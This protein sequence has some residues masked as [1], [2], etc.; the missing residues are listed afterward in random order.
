MKKTRVSRREFLKA[1]A[2]AAAGMITASLL[3]C[4]GGSG[5]GTGAFETNQSW[6]YLG[7]HGITAVYQP[8]DIALYRQLLPEA[9]QMPDSPLVVVSIVSYDTVTKP[10]VPYREGFVMLSCRHQGQTGMYTLTMPV[11]D[12]TANDAGIYLGF[13]KYVADRIDLAL[14][15]GIWN[16]EVVY[17]GQSVMQLK[18]TPSNDTSTLTR[19][20]PGPSCVNLVPPGVGPDI[21]DVNIIGLQTVKTTKGTA[22]TTVDPGQSWGNLLQGAILVSAQLEQ[23][24][25]DWTLVKG[26]GLNSAVVSIAR[27]KSGRTD[28]AVEEAIALLGGIGAV[29]Q[30]RQKI[31]LKPNLVT[32]NPKS[33]TKPEVVE[34]LA[35]LML[36]AGKEVSIGE[37]SAACKNF[38]ILNGV[39]YRTKRKDILDGMQQHIFDALGYSELSRTLGIPLVNLHS[40]EMVSVNVPDPF[41]YDN[42]T[43]HRSLADTDLL[44]SVPVMKTHTMGGVTLGM[45]NLIGTYPG[46]A[47]GTVR[48]L[49]HDKA[50]G[51]EGS[52]VAAAVIDIVRANKLGLV[53]IDASTAMEGN[54]PENGDPVVMNL[55]IA[56]TNPLA[57]DM[58]AASIMGFSSSEIP[59]FIWANKAGMVPGKVSQIEIRGE[60]IAGVQRNFKRPQI[61]PWSKVRPQ[62]GAVEI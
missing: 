40:G 13:P 49:V 48:S 42:I 38:N 47:Y 53:V 33:T 12:K 18:F 16:G 44:C 50:A 20:N 7:A 25:G 46:I 36:A 31:M 58:V 14:D 26:N 56:G 43:L 9:F 8:A 51:V 34:A 22:E 4:S 32:D 17:Q 1:G 28:L 59:S 24:T 57:T 29:T 37:G 52:G 6:R 23:T 10:L 62:F 39:V 45:K 3:G 5:D 11:T 27:I 61:V 30:G 55:I 54:G 2:G 35:R 15:G 21:A 19:S 41:I 60:T